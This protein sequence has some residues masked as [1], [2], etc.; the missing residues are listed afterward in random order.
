MQD[1]FHIDILDSD[2]PSV[3]VASTSAVGRFTDRVTSGAKGQS[4][5][6]RIQGEDLPEPG[7]E[8]DPLESQGLI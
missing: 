5:A 2:V 4:H 3:S 8:V 6:N 1:I 7:F